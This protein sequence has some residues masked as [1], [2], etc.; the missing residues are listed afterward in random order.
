MRV[1][2]QWLCELAGVNDVSPERAAHI[3]T[4]AGWNV[5][6]ITLIDLSEIVV[7]CVISQEPHPTSRSPLWVHQVEVGG[8]ETRQII[9]G[10]DNAV[11]GSLVPVALPGT[12]VPNGTEVRDLKIAGVAGQGML[13]A[14]DELLLGDDH[15]GIMLLDE[16][17]PGQRLDDLIPS[18]AIFDVDVTPNRPDC[19]SHLGLARE[20]ATALG[21]GLP[22]DFMPAFTGGIEPPGTDLIRVDIEAPELCRRYIGAVISDVSVGPSPRWL[23]RRL[24]LC[25]VRP[26]SNVVDV[27]NYVTLEYGQ[28]LHA[29]DLATIRGGRIVVRRARPGEELACLDGETRRLTPDMLV[30]A[31]AERPIALAG[32]IGGEETAVTESAT[33]LLLE[34]AN[35][36]GVNIRA[37][38]RAF[39]LRT[40]ASSRFEKGLSPELALAGARRAARLLGEVAG[41]R[42]H[43]GWADEYPRPQEPVRV[44]FR[45]EQIDA[46]LGVHV[47]LEEMEAILQRL[48]FQVRVQD[49]EWDVLPPVFRLDVSSREDV[50]EE[51]GRMYGYDKVPPTLPGRRR[52]TWVPATP[53]QERRLDPLRH[54]LAGA[55][56]TEVVTPA[57][58]D[59]SLLERL[60][61][62]GMAASVVNPVSEEQDTLRTTLVP[63]LLDVAL[64]NRNRGRPAVDVFEVGRAYI[65]RPDDPAGQPAEPARL[66]ALRSGLASPEAGRTAFLELKGAL[67]RALGRVA[68]V[69]LEYRRATSPLFHPGRCARVVLGEQELGYL[70]ELHPSVLAQFGLDGRAAAFEVELE[71]VLAADP[72]RNA[73]PLP[74]FPAVNRDLAVVVPEQVEA[75]SLLATIE[76]AGGA[77]LESVRA[78]DEYRGG[79]LPAGRKSVAFTMT[80]RSPQRT[81]TDSDADAQLERI[82]QALRERHGATFRDL[83]S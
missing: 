42:V 19:L 38:S 83:T 5:E 76:A 6:E 65:P 66:A 75:A 11:P 17:R 2:Y 45:P 20:L 8:G 73:R 79:Q 48:G 49:G 35:F 43:V 64:R 40:E 7:G 58:V 44:H 36:D 78:F 21:R 3:L 26:I 47:P 61:L 70:G 12:T 37:T 29:F 63:S 25:G 13:C 50:A 56:L 60:G 72:S 55:G 46:I 31:D 82:R 57:L 22:G 67:E 77:L 32:L 69:E 33:D 34:A 15:S 54:A 81:L 39:R 14:E 28:P 62:D 52:S 30:I 16:G 27:T 51:V 80:F 53:S 59:G 24:R 9:A 23:Q 41:G 1:S 68:P 71:P 10:V 74:R 4:M 18:D